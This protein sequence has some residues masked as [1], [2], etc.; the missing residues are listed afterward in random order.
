MD[1][2]L[3]FIDIFLWLTKMFDS[4]MCPFTEIWTNIRALII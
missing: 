2:I 1:T 3:K 4:S